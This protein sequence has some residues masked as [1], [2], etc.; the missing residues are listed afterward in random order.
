MFTSGIK[1]QATRNRKCTSQIYV[2]ELIVVLFAGDFPPT[3]TIHRR[4]DEPRFQVSAAW[5]TTIRADYGVRRHNP[6]LI[7]IVA[8][9]IA[10]RVRNILWTPVINRLEKRI[11][12]E[13]SCILYAPYR[14]VAMSSRGRITIASPQVTP[15]IPSSRGDPAPPSD[16]DLA[17]NIGSTTMVVM[18]LSL[19]QRHLPCHQFQSPHSKSQAVGL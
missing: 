4:L 19:S 2:I 6:F 17:V 16:L 10:P 3:L 8:R 12:L 1:Q 11:S 15:D 9:P 5:I 13:I 18:N 14:H 7:E